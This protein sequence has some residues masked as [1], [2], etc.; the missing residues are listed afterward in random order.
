MLNSTIIEKNNNNYIS[1][2]D[3]KN[4]GIIMLKDNCKLIGLK[5]ENKEIITMNI[6]TNKINFIKCIY[7]INN[8]DKDEYIQIINNK[9]KNSFNK[10]P[11]IEN[12][13]KIMIDGEIK[14]NTLK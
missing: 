14:S 2:I 11:E 9:N 10:N 1:S 4:E 3:S 6:I 5:K 7:N 13:I 12:E 8:E